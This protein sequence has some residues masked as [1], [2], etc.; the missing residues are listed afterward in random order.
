MRKFFTLLTLLMCVG[1]LADAA[2]GDKFS[3]YVNGNGSSATIEDSNAFFA[4]KTINSEGEKV[5]ANTNDKFGGTYNG[6]TYTCGIKIESNTTITFETK[7]V[8]TITIVKSLKEYTDAN[9]GTTTNYDN[10][11]K[12]NGVAVKYDSGVE[13]PGS[14]DKTVRVYTFT[15]QNIGIYEIT[16]DSGEIGILYISVEYTGDNGSSEDDMNQAVGSKVW[17]F[18]KVRGTT[19]GSGYYSDLRNSGVLTYD[20]EK[21][22]G[23]TIRF[24]AWGD[25]N[26]KH[27]PIKD[28]RYAEN[29]SLE[30]SPS[31]PGA[32][33][34]TFECSEDIETTETNTNPVS[35]YISI[36]YSTGKPFWDDDI[37][38]GGTIITDWIP[39]EAKAVWI[40]FNGNKVA[41]GARVSKVEYVT[42]DGTMIGNFT[43]QEVSGSGMI[44]EWT[45]GN[46]KNGVHGL[47]GGVL[48]NEIW[49]F[50]HN[51]SKSS[52]DNGNI[53]FSITGSNPAKP[54]LSV[55]PDSYIYV[56][57][58]AATSTGTVSISVNGSNYSRFFYVDKE[59]GDATGTH[60]F[61][62]YDKIICYNESEDIVRNDGWPY[63]GPRSYKF[64]SD[65]LIEYNGKYYLKLV[66]A[67]GEMKVET[68]KVKLNTT[69][70]TTALYQYTPPV[71]DYDHTT[72]G[73]HEH[74]VFSYD[75]GDLNQTLNGEKDEADKDITTASKLELATGA[76]LSGDATADPT[77]TAPIQSYNGGD[78]VIYKNE[79]DYYGALQLRHGDVV[80]TLTAPDDKLFT[81]SIKIHGYSNRNKEGVNGL[82]NNKPTLVTNLFGGEFTDTTFDYP[83]DQINAKTTTLDFE[84]TAESS[85]SFQF[86]EYQF[87]GIVDAIYVDKNDVPVPQGEAAGTYLEYKYKNGEKVLYLASDVVA[88]DRGGT[89]TYNNA[90]NP[91]Q[92]LWWYFRPVTADAGSRGNMGSGDYKTF[93]V[94]NYPFVNV[95]GVLSTEDLNGGSFFKINA[96]KPK[97]NK[98]AWNMMREPGVAEAAETAQ[99]PLELTVEEDGYFYFYIKDNATGFNSKLVT[100]GFGLVTG[101]E[102]VEID[103]VDPEAVDGPMYNVYGQRVDESYRGLVI[104]NG[105]KYINR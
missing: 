81:S 37:E 60:K 94:K 66:A 28:N 13:N 74:A 53:K 57:V 3:C 79:Y 4:A 39:V 41:D 21:F 61:S 69:G 27:Y 67:G 103:A 90:A 10:G 12:L 82:D 44:S 87:F 86:G 15:N 64:T 31:V 93:S 29:G 30:I 59:A 34:V 35:T 48:D 50:S 85:I 99:E 75:D 40:H 49:H 7:E 52:N 24:Y 54:Y 18:S 25:K 43:T 22:D 84:I 5:S 56:P 95:G 70:T 36:G 89:I 71:L 105:R 32:V 77:G 2:V 9:K 17:D 42:A 104:K 38:A 6:T 76:T 62:E 45:Y 20:D 33:R 92:E 73:E 83:R 101:I 26:D 80:Y 46:Y 47:I 100:S 14:G 16:R 96:P 63:T 19:T 102:E 97:T 65:D 91:D 88:I 98:A 51:T 11:F 1:V 55:Q 72:I 58:P 78:L 8:S 23:S 68:I